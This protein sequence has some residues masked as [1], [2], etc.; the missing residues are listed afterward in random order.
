MVSIKFSDFFEVA[1]SVLEEYGAFDVSILTDLPVFIDPFLLFNSTDPA[2]QEL[3]EGIIRYVKFLRD[4]SITEELTDGLIDAW[5]RFSEVRQK[6][7]G[8]AK[9]GH[10][11]RGLGPEFA[12]ALNRNLHTVFADFGEETIARSSHLEKLCLVS[13]G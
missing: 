12:R 10:S 11:G 9:D 5:Y 2:Y 7:L 3:H 1:P 8:Y 13:D 6:C 4:K